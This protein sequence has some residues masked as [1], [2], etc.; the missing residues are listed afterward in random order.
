MTR[1]LPEKKGFWGTVWNGVK[2]VFAPPVYQADRQA[3]TLTRNADLTIEANKQI[4]ASRQHLRQQELAL[5]E[6]QRQANLDFQAEQGDLNRGLQSE[7]ARLTRELQAQEG[8]LNRQFQANEGSKTREHQEK[9]ARL[10]MELQAELAKLTREFQANEGKLNREHQVQ[11][12]VF[13]SNLQKW[14]LEQQKEL[15]LQLKALD[16][17]L[18]R[19]LRIYDRQTALE[20]IHEQKRQNN[21][22]IWLIAEDIVHS[23]PYQNPIPLRVFLSPPTLRFDRSGDGSDAAKGFPDMEETLGAYL[24]QFFEKYSAHGRPIEFLAGAWTS[25]FFHSQAATKSMFRGL[26]TEPT[27]ILE[28]AAEG[29]FFNLRFGYWGLNWAT[30][31]YK[32]AITMLPW[33]EVLFDFAKTRA[34]RWKEKRD[35]HIA[36]GKKA[37]EFDSRYGVET[38]KRYLSNL[39]IIENERL[40]LED[41]DDPSDIERPYSIHQNDYNQ[42]R[43]FVGICHCI[44][45]GLLADE[46]FLAHVSPEV[47]KSPL[48]PQL[49]PDLLQDMPAEEQEKLVEIVVSFCTMLYNA[50]GRDESGWIPELRLDLAESLLSLPKKSWAE[51]QI[52]ESVKAWLQ[53]RGLSVLQGNKELLDALESALTAGDVE[54]ADRLNR[55]LAAVGKSRQFSAIDSCYNRGIQRCKEEKYSAA[56]VDFTQVIQL[57]PDLAKAYYNRGLAYVKLGQYQ[58]AI[59]DCTQVQRLAPENAS[60]Y[61]NRANAYY[62]LGEYERAIADYN[63]AL[64]LN[65]NLPGVAHS[66]DVAQGVWD[67]K[68]R[69]QRQEEE[70]RN[71]EE[72]AKGR[73]FH[74]EIVTVSAQGREIGRQPGKARQKIL[75]LGGG[76][77]LEMVYIAG[78]TFQM[79]SADGEGSRDERPRH[80]VTVKAFFLGKYPITQE[81]WQA[82]MGNNPSDYKGAKRPVENVSWNDAVEFCSRLSQKTGTTYRLPSEAEWEYACRAGTTTPFHFGETITPDLVNYNGNNPYGSAPKGLYRQETT[83]VGSFPPNAFGLYDMHGNVWE[84]CSDPWHGSYQGAPSDGSSWEAS[85]NDNRVHRGGSWGNRAVLCRSASRDWNSAGDRYGSLG[86]RAAGASWLVA[87]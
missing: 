8:L 83:P 19:E 59:E 75:D 28:S 35:A 10:N 47:R 74:F 62:K 26:R 52:F 58:A 16:A 37:E 86:F 42:L 64:S 45:A 29:D 38:V 79:G 20:V 67:E 11:L 5:Q 14:C 9:L 40:C 46:Y 77:N 32:S 50:V 7:L 44:I 68:K 60:A 15:Q 12:E 70:R 4:E 78:G 87:S 71:S 39:R 22:P 18:A 72:E 55:C 30:Y 3:E 27:L 84:W 49:L 1:A 21:S 73:E 41:G 17:E 81:Q 57:K 31:R 85:G 34:L 25:K 63:Q 33:R 65:P 13:R 23:N 6:F 61:H 43:E 76:V 82:V 56:I 53:L 36:A 51:A 48:L 66:R 2:A 24:Q 69:Q 80:Q 54:Y